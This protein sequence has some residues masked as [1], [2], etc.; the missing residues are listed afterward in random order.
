MVVMVSVIF[1]VCW[2]AD[3]II[4]VLGFYSS[5][6]KANDVTFAIAFTLILF[7]SAINPF[8]YALVNERFW[9]KIKKMVCCKCHRGIVAHAAS[10]TDANKQTNNP[11]KPSRNAE[12]IEL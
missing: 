5:T 12:T 11:A 6:H 2:L 3:G 7:N 4:Y 9:E 8:V 1:A 10:K